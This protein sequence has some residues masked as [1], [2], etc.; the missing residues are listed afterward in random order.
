MSTMTEYSGG[1]AHLQVGTKSEE[2][3]GIHGCSCYL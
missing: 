2:T 3:Q 1:M